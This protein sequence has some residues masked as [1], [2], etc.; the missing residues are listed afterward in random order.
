MAREAPSLPDRRD[1][2]DRHLTS[3]GLLIK[4]LCPEAELDISLVRYEEEDAH[5]HV[6]PPNT[7]TEEERNRLADRLADRTLEILDETGLFVLT[8]VYDRGQRLRR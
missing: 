1:L 2:L 7:L 4:E 6:Y 3:F 8:G 5:I